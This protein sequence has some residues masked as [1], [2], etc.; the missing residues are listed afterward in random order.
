MGGNETTRTSD[1][2]KTRSLKLNKFVLNPWK[3]KYVKTFYI[4]GHR[5]ADWSLLQRK[6]WN[7][8]LKINR[9]RSEYYMKIQSKKHD[10]WTNQRTKK[11]INSMEKSRFQKLGYFGY[12]ENIPRFVGPQGSTTCSNAEPDQSSSKNAMLCNITRLSSSILVGRNTI[13]TNSKQQSP[14]W[15]AKSPSTTQEISAFCGNRRFITAFTRARYLSLFWDR[16]SQS[17]L[18]SYF[19]KIHFNIIHISWVFQVVSF[20][21]ISP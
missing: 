16:Y 7:R 5:Y 19:S 14:S 3:T 11:L 2:E 6:L 20:P 21:Q 9:S 10:G 12:S 15:E 18:P 1:L 17:M 8:S 4:H 13:T